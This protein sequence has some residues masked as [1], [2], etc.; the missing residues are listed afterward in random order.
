MKK[1]T[2]R[3]E[4]AYYERPVVMAIGIAANTTRTVSKP[5]TRTVM[6]IGI[7]VNT[8]RTETKPTTSTVMAIG[9]AMNTTRTAK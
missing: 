6:A 2:K 1:L 9:I 7:A 8:T 3:K 5:T 4:I